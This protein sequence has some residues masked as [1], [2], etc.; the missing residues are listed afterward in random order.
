M[1]KPLGRLVLASVDTVFRCKRFLTQKEN[2][3]FSMCSR[4]APS[5]E[6]FKDAARRYAVACGHP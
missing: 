3:S 5:T 6:A 2:L 1:G 4:I